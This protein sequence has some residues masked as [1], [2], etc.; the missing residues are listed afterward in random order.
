MGRKGSYQDIYTFDTFDEAWQG[1][2]KEC[3]WDDRCHTYTVLISKYTNNGY[4]STLC[5]LHD[6]YKS[7]YVLS[8][9]DLSEEPDSASHYHV[10]GVPFKLNNQ[11]KLYTVTYS[12][13]IID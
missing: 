5:Y 7:N 6:P 9:D 2:A 1:C 3:N 11:M 4:Y 12:I 8:E 10:S 13:S